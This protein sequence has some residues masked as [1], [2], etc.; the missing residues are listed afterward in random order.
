M[1]GS[2]MRVINQKAKRFAVG[3]NVVVKKQYVSGMITLLIGAKGLITG[4]SIH[5]LPDMNLFNIR[6]I[7]LMF[8]NCV[9]SIAEQIANEYLEEV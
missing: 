5:S 8:P 6:V 7:D 1:A 3:K 9:L 2:F 4:S